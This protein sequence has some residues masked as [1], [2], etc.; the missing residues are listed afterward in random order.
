MKSK[1]L[2]NIVL[3]KYQ[4]GDTPTEIHRHLNGDISLVAVKRWCQMIR[5]FDSTHLLG[6]CVTS[7][8]V[9]ALKRIHKKLKIICAEN[10]RY[11]LENFR[12]SFCNK[13]HT[14]IRTRFR[15][16]LLERR[17]SNCHFPMIKRSNGNSFQTG[18]ERISEKK[19]S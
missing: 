14:K 1:D 8:I 10:R 7:W 17:E 2:Q 9:R 15:P 12:G 4:K 6:T 18:L 11:Q 13:C 3:S 16:Q 5:Q 19:A